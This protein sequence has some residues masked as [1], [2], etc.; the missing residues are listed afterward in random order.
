M[1]SVRYHR[2]TG[3]STGVDSRPRRLA[4]RQTVVG[5][6][7]PAG[8]PRYRSTAERRPAR[9]RPRTGARFE[10][11]GSRVRRPSATIPES[12]P[13]RGAAHRVPAP[14][15]DRDRARRRAGRRL[16]VRSA[17]CPER[18]H[19][20]GATTGRQSV[21]SGRAVPPGTA[22]RAEQ[23]TGQQP[24]GC[25]VERRP[26]KNRACGCR[27]RGRVL[28]CEGCG[29]LVVGSLPDDANGVPIV[30]VVVIRELV[31]GSNLSIVRRTD[32]VLCI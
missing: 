26:S 6:V 1:P 19:Q 2:R 23:S 28:L 32:P 25:A 12:E 18:P 24:V 17:V 30:V 3:G 9:R 27:L 13:G 4:R 16:Q 10:R 31:S 20:T 8:S 14:S 15:R 21:L 7:E 11:R 29:G 5:G 22:G